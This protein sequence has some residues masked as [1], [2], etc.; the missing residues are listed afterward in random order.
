V[1]SVD[2][3]T[4]VQALNRTQPM[5]PL[6]P[7][8]LARHQRFAFHFTPTSASWMNQIEPWFGI[9][10]RQA[11]HRGSFNSVKGLT[12]AIDRFTQGWNDH[13]T[14][15]TEPCDP[16]QTALPVARQSRLARRTG[17]PAGPWQRP[18]FS[19]CIEQGRRGCDLRHAPVAQILIEL[20]GTRKHFAHVG[21]VA[22]VPLVDLLIED[23]GVVEHVAHGGYVARIPSAQRL[24]E[25]GRGQ[26]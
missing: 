4:Q 11:V 9:L 6:R 13:A 24:I 25:R 16:W 23:Q 14:C 22:G 3:K 26:K 21:D 7:G 17:T 18:S 20:E 19:A 10:T 15:P 1:L 2:E 8:L 5:L 12:D